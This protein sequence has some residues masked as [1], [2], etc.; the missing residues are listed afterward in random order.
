MLLHLVSVTCRYQILPA[1]RSFC[2]YCSVGITA[3]FIYQA[4]FFTACVSSDERRAEQ[5]RNACCCCIVQ[6][7]Y[8][9]N[10]CSQKSF[11]DSFFGNY[12]APFIIKLPVKASLI[13]LFDP[14]ISRFL[15]THHTTSHIEP[16]S[17]VLIS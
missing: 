3:N 9:P 16:N 6:R 1:L 17:G 11:M 13:E 12:Y 10:S 15:Q 2:V 8:T 4:T 7:G 14:G 5:E